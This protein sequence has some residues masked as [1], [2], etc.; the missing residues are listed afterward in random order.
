MSERRGFQLK[1][2]AARVL[3]PGCKR[4]DVIVIREGAHGRATTPV[5]GEGI[6]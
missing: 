3:Y 4:D 6:A 1:G 5:V 2:V